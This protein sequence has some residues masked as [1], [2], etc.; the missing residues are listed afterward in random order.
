MSKIAV[1]GAGAWGTAIA[2]N[3]AVHGNDVAI[4]ARESEVVTAINENH[5]NTVFLKDIAL[6]EKIIATGS[7][8]EAVEAADVIMIVTPAQAL[9]SV[10]VGIR[11]KA[12]IGKPVVLCS[13][14]FEIGTGMMLSAIAKEE[15]PDNPIAIMTGP[16]FASEVAKGLPCAVTLAA[17]TKDIAKE[18]RDLIGTKKLRPYVTDDLIGTQIGSAIKNVLAIAS[19][20]VIGKGLGE[21]ARAALITRG[22]SEMARLTSAMGGRK[23]TLMGMCGMGDLMLTATSM[24]SR[25]YSFGYALGQGETIDEFLSQRNAVTEGYHT[26]KALMVLAKKQAVEMPICEMVYSILHEGVSLDEAVDGMLS[27]PFGTEA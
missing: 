24:Q 25:N 22:L 1:I 10:C 7:L 16:T 5:E 12:I 14:G 19:G 11:S 3:L 9:R 2:Q 21:S 17:E 8:F 23:E 20:I 4:W 18:I 15:L 26:S 27:R 6:D 13:K